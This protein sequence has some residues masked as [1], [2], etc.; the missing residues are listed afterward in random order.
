M[1]GDT[2]DYIP[3]NMKNLLH[4]TMLLFFLKSNVSAQKENYIWVNGHD[5]FSSNPI[6]GGI[7]ID[8][9]DDSV[10]AIKI[11]R[12]MD[13]GKGNDASIC[14]SNGQLLFYSNGCFVAN[15]MHELMENGDSLNSGDVFDIQCGDESLGYTSG[16]QSS[17]ILPLPNSSNLYYIFHKRI[18][19]VFNP[20]DVLTKHL[21]YSVIDISQNEGLGKVVE[22][23]VLLIEDTVG[24][25]EM[26]AVRHANGIDWWLVSPG[27]R[28][29]N[30][31]IVKT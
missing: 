12:I 25:G 23:N 30:Y 14:D 28:N 13:F 17:I 26:T 4:I 8:F 15:K 16:F 2:L 22:K 5:S 9:N 10:Q 7:N 6:F 31:F 18:F 27:D 24:Y 21:L 20:F 19:Y 29:N 3:E 11:D 1:A